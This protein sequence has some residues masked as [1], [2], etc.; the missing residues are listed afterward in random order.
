MGVSS[1]KTNEEKTRATVAQRS[2]AGESSEEPAK[3]CRPIKPLFL[4]SRT[5]DS[6]GNLDDTTRPAVHGGVRVYRAGRKKHH[7]LE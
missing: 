1:R 3:E 5:K 7:L 4:T 6:L 2:A